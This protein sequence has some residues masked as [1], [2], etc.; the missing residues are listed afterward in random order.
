MAVPLPA[1]LPT[2]A[3]GLM[4][5]IYYCPSPIG[6]GHRLWFRVAA[7]GYIAAMIVAPKG[8][9]EAESIAQLVADARAVRPPRLQLVTAAAS[10]PPSWSASGLLALF[11]GGPSR[12]APESHL[13]APA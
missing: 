3:S 4:P 9:G 13:P 2:T 1:P 7:D 6:N 5:G 10:P 12:R 8:Q 11:R